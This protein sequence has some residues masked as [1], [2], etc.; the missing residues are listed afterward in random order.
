MI[1]RYNYPELA[2]SMEGYRFIPQNI[3]LEQFQRVIPKHEHSEGCYEIHYIPYGCGTVNLDGSTYALDADSLYV[4]GPHISHEQF[5]AKEKPMAEYCIFLQTS[6]ESGQV[7]PDGSI[8]RAFLSTPVWIGRDTQNMHLIMQKLFQELAQKQA[9]YRS[10]VRSLL[11]Q[12]I[13]YMVRNYRAEI[14]ARTV[15]PAPEDQ[16]SLILDESFLY[17]YAT[18]TLEEL[19][20]RLALSVRQTERLVREKYGQTFQ[21][22]SR[23]EI[24]QWTVSRP[25][26]PPCV[27]FG[28]RRFNQLNK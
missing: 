20:K 4:T 22:S 14:S 19:A 16:Q 12:V 27:P 10:I 8:V 11:Q 5:P 3:V 17:D 6:R 25:L 7:S 18:L 13:V 24:V 23:R 2:F 28:T 9:G 1:T 21:Q 26:T 15:S